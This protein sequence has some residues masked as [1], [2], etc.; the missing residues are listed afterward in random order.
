MSK[1]SKQLDSE[2][3]AATA[4]YTVIDRDTGERF[5]TTTYSTRDRAE[6]RRNELALKYGKEFALGIG[7]DTAGT[8]DSDITDTDEGVA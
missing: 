1:T 5:S 6:R 3:A 2:I 4:H 7:R 8:M